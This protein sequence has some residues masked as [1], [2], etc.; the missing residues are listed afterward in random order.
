MGN[1]PHPRHY[2]RVRGE[3]AGRPIVPI[4][5]RTVVQS[6]ASK[7]ASIDVSVQL[8]LAVISFVDVVVVVDEWHVKIV[9]V[10]VYVTSTSTGRSADQFARNHRRLYETDCSGARVRVQC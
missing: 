4:C 3:I 2:A 10:H 7:V 1:V 6:G 9:H 5:S 8:P